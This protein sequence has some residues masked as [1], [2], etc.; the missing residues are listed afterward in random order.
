MEIESCL[1]SNKSCSPGLFSP[2]IFCAVSE[3]FVQQWFHSIPSEKKKT[4]IPLV[5]V[6]GDGGRERPPE[7]MMRLIDI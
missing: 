3:E 7:P 2:S 5:S 4:K 1:L 6:G